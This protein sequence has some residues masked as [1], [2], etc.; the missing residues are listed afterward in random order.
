[1]G[2]MGWWWVGSGWVGGCLGGLN[3]R[4][5]IITRHLVELLN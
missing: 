2:G 4:I 5:I 1:M 3:R